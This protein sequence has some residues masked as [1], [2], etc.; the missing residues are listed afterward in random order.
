M[1]C[2][3]GDGTGSGQAGHLRT[4]GTVERFNGRFEDVLQSHHFHSGEEPE[5]TL[6]RYL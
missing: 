2:C 5:T 1:T 6:H 4:N 3:H